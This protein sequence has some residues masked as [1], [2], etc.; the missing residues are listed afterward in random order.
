M[1]IPTK[2]QT[3]ELKEQLAS[4]QID[5]ERLQSFL[6]DGK[7]PQVDLE[8]ARRIMRKNFLGPEEAKEHLGIKITEAPPVPWSEEVLRECT[9]AFILILVPPGLS[10][11]DLSKK[12]TGLRKS[13]KNQVDLSISTRISEEDLHNPGE[14]A[15]RLID[16]TQKISSI[17][18]LWR[19]VQYYPARDLAYMLALY[20]LARGIRLKA[21]FGNSWCAR[22]LIFFGRNPG[23]I[24]IIRSE[25]IY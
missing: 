3:T 17:D 10:I 14:L 11:H 15:W 23:E 13:H 18:T 9:K 20:Y 5:K 22:I 12:I 21:C 25:D 4:G 6:E 1:S 24:R 16:K 2:K 8:R 7:P 19:Y